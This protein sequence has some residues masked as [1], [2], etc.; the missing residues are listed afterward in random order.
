MPCDRR[1]RAVL[2]ADLGLFNVALFLFAWL[3]PTS[4]I[5]AEWLTM[6]VSAL[7]AV[8]VISHALPRV[9]LPADEWA[10]LM[11]GAT[12]LYVFAVYGSA[13]EIPV[14]LKVPFLAFLLSGS[15][16]GYAAH[17]ID[18]GPAHRDRA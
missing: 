15:M 2:A 12:G 16:S 10:Y 14:Y 17:V 8:G 6:A 4:I 5:F 13:T 7:C 11:T 3:P 1:W 18:G 9:K